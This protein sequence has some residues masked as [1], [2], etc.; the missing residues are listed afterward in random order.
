[1]ET[2]LRAS[3]PPSEPPE[4]LLAKGTSNLHGGGKF[5]SVNS[6]PRVRHCHFW[7][8]VLLSAKWVLCGCFSLD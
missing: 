6:P 3:L 5:G 2:T 8:S 4:L 7:V 1:M